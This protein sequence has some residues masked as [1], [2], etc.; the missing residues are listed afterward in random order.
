MA[1]LRGEDVRPHWRV[2]AA[3]RGAGARW[4][5]GGRGAA[6]RDGADGRIGGELGAYRRLCAEN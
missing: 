1:A 3:R 4:V 6:G 5:R 2:A